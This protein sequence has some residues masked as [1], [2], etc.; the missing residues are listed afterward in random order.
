MNNANVK[1]NILCADTGKM[2]VLTKAEAIKHFGE[3]EWDEV[4]QGYLPQYCV[5]EAFGCDQLETA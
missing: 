4:R 1:Y 3:K 5:T 2:V